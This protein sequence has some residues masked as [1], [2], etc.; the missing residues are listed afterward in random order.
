MTT[1]A[2]CRRAFAVLAALALIFGL[3]VVITPSADAS[4]TF[5]QSDG[6]Y[7]IP[8]QDGSNV[9]VSNDHHDHSPS[10]DRIDMWVGKGTPIVASAS[11]WIRAVVDFNGG[12]PNA[13]DGVAT[14]GTPQADSLEENCS[15]GNKTVVGSCADYN[16]YVWIEH[17]NG[18]W[19][20]YSHVGTGTASDHLTVGDWINAGE[21]IGLEGDI[22]A[23]S[24]SHLHWEVGVPTDPND[25]TPFSTLGG[26]FQGTNVVGRIC[27]IGGNLFVTD[28]SYTAAACVNQN[29]TADAGGPYE[30][31]E[32]TALVVDG[33]LSTDPDG[34]PLTYRWT[35][36][37]F[38]NDP[39]EE[40][41]IF[42]GGDNGTQDVVLTVYDQVEALRHRDVA[43]ITVNN[44]APT[45]AIDP[46]TDRFIEEGDTLTVYAIFG[47][48]GFW[49]THSATIDW[50][51]PSGYAGLE[52]DAP[53]I[54][55][56]DP[57]GPGPLVGTV[58]A[59]Y[60]FGED[61]GGIPFEVAVTVT[62][63]DGASTTASFEVAVANVAPT[64]SNLSATAL[65]EN[66]STTLTG[67]IS[68]PGTPDTFTLTVDWG[69]PLSP[70]NVEIFNLPAGTTDFS[71]GHQYLDDNP[72]GTAADSYAV[73]VTVTDDDGARDIDGT[74]VPISNV[75]PSIDA[76]SVTPTVDENGTVSLS[77]SFSDVGTLDTH[78]V[79]IEWGD[80]S[81]SPATVV[82]GAGSGTFSAMHQYLD[83]DPTGTP[84]DLQTITVTVTDDDT[85]SQVETVQSL[86][87]NVEPV[88]TSVASD[89]TF[90]DTTEEGDTVTVSGTFTDVGTLDSHAATIDWGD[91]NVTPATVVGGAGSGTFTGDHAYAGGGVYT[92]TVAVTD[93]DTG[94]T[95][96]T[97][98]AVVSGVGVNGGVLQ[99]VGTDGDDHVEVFVDDDNN[100]D[101]FAS[102]VL[103][104]HRL[105]D[106]VGI[107][108]VEMWLR[109]GD[110]HGHLHKS[111][112][113]DAAIHGGGGADML[114]GGDGNDFIEGGDAND[115][116]WGRNGDDELRG[117]DGDDRLTGG[118]GTDVLIGGPGDDVE[119]Q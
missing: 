78:T 83:D 119:K 48:L 23:A 82:Q 90:E 39:S 89:A 21:L 11:G 13:G 71:I 61:D 25:S 58:T 40:L 74:S 30:I 33:S 99:V 22:G 52:V 66:G 16:N 37:M 43:T 72:T 36:E 68:D 9:T 62:D 49:D 107:S 116:I 35:P 98:L 103:P 67:T 105:F 86:V 96:D 110:D 53:S 29:P 10:K 8:Y 75:S 51:V 65:S 95:S 31:D 115:Q 111:I 81:S 100:V 14:D 92:V 38:F 34:R 76:L 26:F 80:G 5:A 108:S 109:D 20:K 42:I 87:K 118:K 56:D 60:R 91:G 46:G 77:G 55:I 114:W 6:I 47:D 94:D 17:P 15:G 101:V 102:F 32:G 84:Q 18:E 7:R 85:G 12:T 50:G 117:D 54:S 57:G 112:T 63:D 104:N 69:D 113:L 3:M 24:G 2:L 93:D 106:L 64:L 28:Q 45:L 44:V 59:S 97:T 88:I 4:H 79:D 27:D 73:G 19:S 1:V 41:A 70:G